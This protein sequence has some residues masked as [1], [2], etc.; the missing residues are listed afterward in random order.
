MARIRRTALG[1]L[2]AAIT[3]LALPASSQ[4]TDVVACTYTGE[5]SNLTDIPSILADVTPGG[6]G[7]GAGVETGSYS[8]ATAPFLNTVDAT[9]CLH[10]DDDTP[11]TDPNDTGLYTAKVAADG[12]Y[13]NLLCGTGTTDGSAT[14]TLLGPVDSDIDNVTFD[15]H[16]D[17]VGGQG[18]GQTVADLSQPILGVT[19]GG[20]S[21]AT[22]HHGTDPDR[23]ITGAGTVHIIGHAPANT[24]PCVTGSVSDFDVLG[25]IAG[26]F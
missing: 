4:A 14:L 12:T 22:V 23:P 3:A 9:L 7:N 17:F 20:N 25:D 10:V 18:V 5:T 8:F 1:A 19:V 24:I 15:Y 16:I 11:L 13:A 6:G 2:A 26:F 21:A